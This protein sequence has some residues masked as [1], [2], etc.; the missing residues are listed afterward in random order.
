MPGN[1]R[2]WRLVVAGPHRAWRH[3]CAAL[4]RPP[5]PHAVQ[6][7]AAGYALDRKDA[8]V[9]AELGV[10]DAAVVGDDYMR[11]SPG[12]EAGES[13]LMRRWAEFLEREHKA[14]AP[15]TD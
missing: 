11:L 10:G 12:E 6:T 2:F 8:A 5:H 4:R 1:A 9:H 15:Y 7:V 14:L 13:A 3:S